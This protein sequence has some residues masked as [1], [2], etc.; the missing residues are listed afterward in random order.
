MKLL[1]CLLV[2]GLILLAALQA[3]PARNYVYILTGQSNSLGAVK[4]SPASPEEL[5]RYAS[6]ALLWNGNM[7]RD[8]GERFDPNPHWET[9]A[10][11]LPRYGHLCMGPEY[12]FAY[13]MQRHGWHASQ[14]EQL[15]IIKASLDG[16]GNSFWLPG[17]A[18][19]KSLTSTVKA[20][21][22][23]LKGE[24]KV[25]ALLYLQGE[26]DKG[27]EITHAP[28]RFLD[29][30]KRLQSLV[31]KGL[32]YAVAGE[33]ATWK[34]GREEKDAQGH[35]TAAA[36]YAMARRQKKIGWVRTRDLEKIS[37][38]DQMGV[39]YNGTSQIIIGARYAYAVAVL[40]KLPF[41][42]TRGDDRE[43]PLNTPAA[44]WGDKMPGALEVATWDASSLPGQS[45][46]TQRVAWAGLVVEECPSP[47]GATIAAAGESAVLGLGAQGL[48]L[49]SGALRLACPV[50]VTSDQVWRVD[51]GGLL[52]CGSAQAPISLRGTGCI[53]LTVAPGAAVELHLSSAP[54]HRWKL[55]A[56]EQAVRATIAGKPAGF[57][58]CEGGYK[59]VLEP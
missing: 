15:C 54:T 16:G 22:A 20:A 13:M 21:L 34:N 7:V 4:G 33:C 37:R 32:P 40:E 29:L 50:E 9:V 52:T 48:H 17:G 55:S 30:H 12:G 44:W 25:C 11:Q 18:A 38:G 27:A 31:K 45:L 8:S 3:A 28:D 53:S 39:H 57:V 26:S 41:S 43:A 59:L 56:P 19:W 49:K 14:G 5:A 47:L 6:R 1:R 24:T 35:T 46:L 42:P 10:P 23:A 51:A 36:M 2:M 58:A